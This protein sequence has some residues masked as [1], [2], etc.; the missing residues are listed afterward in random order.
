[1]STSFVLE[2]LPAPAR[3][4]PAS[5]ANIKRQRVYILPTRAGIVFSILLLAMLLGAINYNNSLAY[6]LVFLL[7]SLFL[8]C[9]L[10]TH[11]NLSGLIIAGSRPLPVFAGETALFPVSIDNG[12]GPARTAIQLD[13]QPRSNWWK[14]SVPASNAAVIDVRPDQKQLVRIPVPAE[15]RGRLPLERVVISSCFPL[16]LFY[17]WSYLQ[18]EQY[19]LVYPKPA[20]ST[21][22][23]DPAPGSL[24]GEDGTHDG[25]NDFIG[26]RQY[27]PGDSI[28]NI[29]WKV[30][31]REQ[32][33]LVKRFSGD[34]SHTLMLT[35]DDVGHLYDIEARL[36]QLCRWILLAERQEW[37]YAL[38]IPGAH[39]EPGRGES[40]RNTCLEALARF[41]GEHAG[42]V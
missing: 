9:M 36:S 40:H 8:V 13:C 34:G 23:P 37:N 18:L 12:H 27:H 24:Q 41:G 15:R 16:G 38:A 19:C 21:R 14:I 35:W 30:L 22:L 2:R 1:M 5:F 20:G 33:L 31:A 32:P 26:F 29:A 7:G 6:I 25:T 39:I 17:A 4:D 42:K 3:G 11:R 28:R 10:H